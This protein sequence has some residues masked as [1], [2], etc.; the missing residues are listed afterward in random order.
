MRVTQTEVADE[1]RALQVMLLCNDLEGPVD[2]ALWDY[3]QKHLTS[4]LDDFI[5]G[6]TR[7]AEEMFSSEKKF[8]TTCVNTPP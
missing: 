4:A 2:A 5:K 7:T 1:N 6:S 8:M 3:G